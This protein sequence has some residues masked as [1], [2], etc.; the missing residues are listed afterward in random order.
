MIS[1]KRKKDEPIEECPFL[2]LVK[3]DKN[4]ASKTYN[5]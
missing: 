3:D 1:M 5:N 4:K 2:Y